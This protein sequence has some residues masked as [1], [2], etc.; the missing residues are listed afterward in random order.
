MFFPKALGA[1]LCINAIPEVGYHL[2]ARTPRN[3]GQGENFTGGG[4][5]RQANKVQVATNRKLATRANVQTF[6]STL[7][8]TAPAVESSASDRPFNVNGDTFVNL[9]AA[10]QCGPA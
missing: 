2:A 6:T 7:G 8:G 10:L 5:N 4:N 9:A 3:F 1:L